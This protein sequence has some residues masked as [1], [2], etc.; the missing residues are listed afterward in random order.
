L[1]T[2]GAVENRAFEIGSGSDEEPAVAEVES[3]DDR[4]ESPRA[5]KAKRLLDF[6]LGKSLGKGG[7]VE[8][9]AFEI[10]SGSDEEPAVAEVESFDDPVET[11]FEE[12]RAPEP[13]PRRLL[14]LR[15]AETGAV[16]DSVKERRFDLRNGINEDAPVA[17]V[18]SFDDPPPE[19]PSRQPKRL[20]SFRPTPSEDVQGP[21]NEFTTV[22]EEERTRPKA[23]LLS[24]MELT[25]EESGEA[26]RSRAEDPIVPQ[27]GSDDP[28]ANITDDTSERRGRASQRLLQEPSLF[29]GLAQEVVSGLTNKQSGS[30]S[31]DEAK[32]QHTGST[33]VRQKRPPATQKNRIL[34]LLDDTF[35]N[36]EPTNESRASADEV[37]ARGPPKPIPASLRKSKPSTQ[38]SKTATDSPPQRLLKVRGSNPTQRDGEPAVSDPDAS[39]LRPSVEFE[40]D[41]SIPPPAKIR[42]SQNSEPHDPV[43]VTEATNV[44][45]NYRPSPPRRP[46]ADS[47]QSL[48]FSLKSPLTRRAMRSLGIVSKDLQLPTDA[49]LNNC[50]PDPEL[51]DTIRQKL[52]EDREKLIHDIQDEILKLQGQSDSGADNSA[53]GSPVSERQK[54]EVERLLLQVLR[55]RYRL[56]AHTRTVEMEKQKQTQRIAEMEAQRRQA[57]GK[58]LD[59]LNTLQRR[60]EQ[61]DREDKRKG[62]AM[63]REVLADM[64]Q[65]ERKRKEHLESVREQFRRENERRIESQ[66]AAYDA[67]LRELKAEHVRLA[68]DAKAR[69]DH[70]DAE[71]KAAR[72]RAAAEKEQQLI[73]N[74]LKRKQRELEVLRKTRQEQL[75]M[76]R[77]QIAFEVRMKQ[78]EAE[79][80]QKKQA[81]QRE[82]RERIL[83]ELE[84]QKIADDLE[85][86]LRKPEMD[87]GFVRTL[88]DQ[89]DIDLA[90]LQRRAMALPG[91]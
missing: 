76:E 69:D 39:S 75:E 3:F 79:Q 17:Q 15:P 47:D 65:K 13:Q 87:M 58:T 60:K 50:S 81:R 67:H 86:L 77:K 34:D 33:D 22:F 64:A 25:G 31:F 74:Q 14:A 20:L 66:K 48:P 5:P 21:P 41:D 23:R 32:D 55:E 27:L 84:R 37:V 8:N 71:L 61:Q 11:G 73:E 24:F 7:A 59:L 6:G 12:P 53:V 88:A 78:F 16:S 62:N 82:Q 80:K 18:E 38:S 63:E 46:P 72:E 90:D 1:G 36:P 54:R 45:G 83:A 26:A 57:R 44:I 28:V 29:G 35:A 89:Y 49:E 52:L 19:E 4:V 91:E 30:E 43:M 42:R 2:G 9:R 40:S 51:K 70:A 85:S 68:R 56:D 10:G